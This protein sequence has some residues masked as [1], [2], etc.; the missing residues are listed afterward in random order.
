MFYFV[1]RDKSRLYS[2]HC[3]DFY[4]SLSLLVSNIFYNLC[5]ML[6]ALCII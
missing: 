4:L 2:A 1:R 5:P 6:Y 3:F